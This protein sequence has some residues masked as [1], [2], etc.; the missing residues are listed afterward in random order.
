MLTTIIIF[1]PELGSVAISRIFNVQLAVDPHPE[2]IETAVILY[3]SPC[4]YSKSSDWLFIRCP[5]PMLIDPLAQGTQNGLRKYATKQWHYSKVIPLP[6]SKVWCTNRALCTKTPLS[7]AKTSLK[8]RTNPL[9]H[10][11]RL[12]FSLHI[13]SF[14]AVQFILHK[15][16]QAVLYGVAN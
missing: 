7:N 16:F 6:Y 2:H 11:V 5:V 14:D 1:I 12:S 15:A 9:I 8:L 13:C 4:S 3:W 10:R